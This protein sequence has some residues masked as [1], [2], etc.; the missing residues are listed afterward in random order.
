[1]SRGWGVGACALLLTVAVGCTRETRSSELVP[2]PSVISPIA[3]VGEHSG[4]RLIARWLDA[5]PRLEE[6][7][8]KKIELAIVDADETSATLESPTLL[9]MSGLMSLRNGDVDRA[10]NFADL[11]LAS[12]SRHDDA[13]WF[14]FLWDYQ[15]VWPYTLTAPWVSALTQGLALSLFDHR[16]GFGIHALGVDRCVLGDGN[17]GGGAVDGARR[18]KDDVVHPGSEAR[19]DEFDR[20]V[21]VVAPVLRGRCHRFTDRFVGGEVH[22]L[23]DA[24]FVTGR[25]DEVAV[26]DVTDDEWSVDDRLSAAEFE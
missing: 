26:G 7:Y 13:L 15:A 5:E 2:Q 19:L 4:G 6:I 18:R 14:P 25:R 12:S 11:L 21:D 17:D 9:A 16:L 1:V 8:A 23:G 24:V 22:E 3:E 20:A 10:Q